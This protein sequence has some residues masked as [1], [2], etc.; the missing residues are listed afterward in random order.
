M[1]DKTHMHG[2]GESYSGVIPAKQPNK[3][4]KPPAEVV[5]GRPLTKENA[6]QSNPCWTPSQRSGPI[7]LDRVRKAAKKDGKLQFT[8]LLHHVNID[9]LRDSYHSLKK[10][11]APG[12]DGVRWEEYGQGLEARPARA[13]PS[14]SISSATVAESLDTETRWKATTVGHCGAGRQSRTARGGDR[15]QPDLGGG[16]SGLFIRIPAGAQP[17]RCIGCAVRRDSA[18]EGELGARFGRP[19]IFRYCFIL[20]P[21]S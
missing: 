10:Q 13:N 21:D 8:A 7:G 1:S 19:V 3:S 6:E 17:A 11:A 2:G 9:L 4:G 16:L 14:R 15:S 5:E 20:P 18:Q 12:V